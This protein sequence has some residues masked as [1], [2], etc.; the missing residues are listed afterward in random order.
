MGYAKEF[1]ER[2][3]VLLYYYDVSPENVSILLGP[4]RRTLYRW[5]KTFEEHGVVH[6]ERHNVRTSRWTQDVIRGVRGFLEENPC[7][8]LEE[9]K[10][11]VEEHFPNC[12][13][14]SVPT[15]CRALRFDLNLS[16]K[17]ITKRAREASSTSIDAYYQS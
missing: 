2:A 10:Q 16:R 5:L 12:F 15:I 8:Y 9:I 14:T 1:K 3:I 17:V 7:A 6:Q 4:K 13:N 11:F